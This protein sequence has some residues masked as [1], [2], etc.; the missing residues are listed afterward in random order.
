LRVGVSIFVKAIILEITSVSRIL[1][2][3]T[4]RL[5]G[6]DFRHFLKNFVERIG[7]NK[8]FWSPVD[9]PIFASEE[10]VFSILIWNGNAV[11]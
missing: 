6:V 2:I 8:T 9:D 3:Q 10:G 1:V 11:F 5:S 7:E 4:L